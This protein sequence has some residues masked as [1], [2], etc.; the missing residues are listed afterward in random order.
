MVAQGDQ[1]FGARAFLGGKVLLVHHQNQHGGL[2]R[3]LQQAGELFLICGG[4]PLKVKLLHH[5]AALLGQKGQRLA[6]FDEP[7]HLQLAAVEA[8]EVKFLKLFRRG[9]A[10]Q[11]LEIQLLEV[12]FLPVQ[13]IDPVEMPELDV[14]QQLVFLLKDHPVPAFPVSQTLVACHSILRTGFCCR[15]SNTPIPGP[16]RSQMPFGLSTASQASCFIIA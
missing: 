15:V 6:G 13:Q 9:Q 11:P 12:L 8:V 7:V 3:V 1:L 14:L 2:R 5:H 10:D 4:H 16:S